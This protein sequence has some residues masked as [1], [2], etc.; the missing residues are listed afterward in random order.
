MDTTQ[1][2]FTASSIPTGALKYSLSCLVN[3]FILHVCIYLQSQ[4]TPGTSKYR[5]IFHGMYRVTKSVDSPSISAKWDFSSTW[6]QFC[7]NALPNVTD[8][9]MSVIH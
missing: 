9:L 5:C 7:L 1:D 6:K 8:D 3:S 2:A 4:A